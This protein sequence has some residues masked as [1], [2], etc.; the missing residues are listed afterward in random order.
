MKI[1]DLYPNLYWLSDHGDPYATGIQM[2]L[3]RI[4][5]Q[6]S[7]RL[8]AQ[9]LQASDSVV[10]TNVRLASLLQHAYALTEKPVVIPPLLDAIETAKFRPKADDDQL[11][12]AYFGAFYTPERSGDILIRFCA[13][14]RTY[15]PAFA[16]RIAIHVY[17]TMQ[18]DIADRLS[19]EPL[20]QLKPALSRADAQMQMQMSQILLHIGNDIDFLL[21]SKAVEYLGF[22][23]ANPGT[24]L[25]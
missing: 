5:R 18:P 22:R 6:H 21:P 17:G 14:L 7:K 2:P 12:L 8:E 16:Q 25:S 20:I 11:I 13:L 4:L 24:F 10:V 19:R 23:S 15:A 9:V 3:A 1:K